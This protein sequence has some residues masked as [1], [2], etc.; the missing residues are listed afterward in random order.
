M[1]F[2]NPYAALYSLAVIPIIF[3]YFLKQEK[4]AVYVSSIIPWQELSESPTSE[5]KT[6]KMDILFILQV[7]F[8]LA[9]V[10]AL[11]RFYLMHDVKVKHS[12]L[13]MD[14]SA[15]MLTQEDG[16]TRLEKAKAQLFDLIDQKNR[17]DS[18]MLITAGAYPKKIT[19]FTDNKTIL[20]QAV[21]KIKAG[22]TAS[23][24]TD[25]LQLAASI[26]K[27]GASRKIIIFSDHAD[28]GL[29]QLVHGQKL[30]FK[31]IGKRSDNAAITAMDIHQGLY[32]YSEHKAFITLHN[33]SQKTQNAQLNIYL[34]EQKLWG[35]PITLSAGQST[36]LPFGY[37][38]HP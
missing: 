12:V 17:Q 33:F 4:I 5:T 9:L 13:I 38:N 23:S 15:S 6:F 19:D 2:L 34:N 14:T 35:K 36:T 29:R 28:A 24:L 20:E 31:L 25:A 27:D 37:L 1:N 26:S 10:F 22:E 18:I 8:I 32:D 3:F 16:E 30:D 21:K 7:L 11:I